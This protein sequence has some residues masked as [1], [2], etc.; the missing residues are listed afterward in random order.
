MAIGLIG[1]LAVGTSS[2]GSH[3]W[4]R[5]REMLNGISVGA[6]PD[7]LN[8]L[9]QSWGLSTFSPRALQEHGYAA[10][11]EMLRASLRHVGGLR[12]DHVLGLR[13]LWLVPEDR[14]GVVEGKSVS[15]RVALGWCRFLKQKKQSTTKKNK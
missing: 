3:A 15:V 2:G 7:L 1:Y 12:I 6:P 11:I 9:G 5:Q 13:R 8:A 14:Q 10:F 4:S